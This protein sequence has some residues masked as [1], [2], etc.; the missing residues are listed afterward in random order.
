MANTGRSDM[1]HSQNSEFISVPQPESG[2][3]LQDTE[4]E[5][6][7]ARSEATFCFKLTQFSK[8]EDAVFSP[9]CYIRNLS[10][11]IK[12]MP[13]TR[14]TQNRT[15]QKALGFFLQCNGE[16][17]SS[18]WSCNAVAELRLL[19]V[20]SDAAAFTR[21][22]QH[23]FCSKTIH[24]Y[25]SDFMNNLFLKLKQ[26]MGDHKCPYCM[27]KVTNLFS[28]IKCHLCKNYYHDSCSKRVKTRSDGAFIKCCGDDDI[29]DISDGVSSDVVNGQGDLDF[30]DAS[31]A[32]ENKLEG[33]T[34]T[35]ND[36]KQFYINFEKFMNDKLNKYNAI[37]NKLDNKIDS[38]NKM[39][40]EQSKKIEYNE[41]IVE[42]AVER[43]DSIEADVRELINKECNDEIVLNEIKERMQRERNIIF[44]NIKENASEE[45]DTKTINNL[46]S[47]THIDLSGLQVLRLG[48]H[49]PSIIRP[50]RVRFNSLDDVLWILRNS[51]KIGDGVRCVRRCKQAESQLVEIQLKL[52]EVE[53][54]RA[55]LEEKIQKVQLE[56]K[57]ITL[58]L[59]EAELK[60]SAALK[61][62]TTIESQFNETQAAL[63]E[64]TKQNLSLSSKLRQLEM[65]KEQLHYQLE[66]EQ[67]A[68]RNPKEQLTIPL[69]ETKEKAEDEAEQAA[70]LEALQ[71]QLTEL[72][73]ANDKLKKGKKEIATELEDANI[74][75]QMQTQKVSELEKKQK[76][77][78]KVLAAVNGVSEQMAAERDAAEREAGEEETKALSIG[79][80]LYESSA[81]IKELKWR[82]MQA[83][84]DKPVTDRDNPDKNAHKLENAKRLLESLLG[85]FHAQNNELE[86]AELQL[87]G[88]IQQLK[89]QF[90]RDRQA[91]E[92]QFEKKLRGILNV[93]SDLE[94]ELDE[95]L[96]QRTAAVAAKK[97]LEG[98]LKEVEGQIEL[99]C[100]VKEDALKQLK[101]SQQQ[102]KEAYRDVEEA[103]TARDE[104]SVSC[105]H[106][107]RKVKS[108]EADLMQLSEDLSS[109]E[110][111]RRAVAAERDEKQEELKIN[112][113]KGNLLVDE[114]HHLEARIALLE[115]E[116][117]EVQSNNEMFADKAR[118][119]QL[120][121]E[122]L[123]LEFEL[124]TSQHI[125]TNATI[126]M[127]EAKIANLVENLEIK[128]KER[129]DECRHA[130]QYKEQVEKMNA[131][132]NG[133]K[134]LLGEA[135]EEI[136][137]EKA[138]KIE[139]QYD[140]ADMKREIRNLN[141]KLRG[142]TNTVMLSQC[143]C[144]VKGKC[145][146]DTD[147]RFMYIFDAG[148]QQ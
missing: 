11:K 75:L 97:N 51:K 21:K 69:A 2:M 19:S 145:N 40:I 53:R 80:E 20:K 3:V 82:W 92:E 104:L 14:Y 129:E 102:C 111:A 136:S 70:T 6:D 95:E 90:E 43:I 41:K 17:D 26:E 32:I 105:E 10:W 57:S 37:Y 25:I 33:T 116:L 100:Q 117:E 119:A 76:H 114:K 89:E 125:K 96:N 106:A 13:R 30:H 59:E 61:S 64:E 36:F 27:K 22:L 68:K 103:R 4:M 109:S 55:E 58:Q 99:Q 113:L 65:E 39:L 66:E 108:L 143:A 98:D 148:H 120:T 24:V 72:M 50:L 115:K 12:V 46:L 142:Y 107:E 110:R 130:N 44:F 118:K 1:D 101:K 86:D 137:K 88:Y 124:E 73:V 47:N 15:K 52:V 78:D 147:V 112:I 138:L 60:A 133:L 87:E 139:A 29:L 83:E 132:V 84:L 5:E 123:T 74:D 93:L 94:G 38:S 49:N 8:L 71:K 144:T 54:N 63:E 79:R 126:A 85:E 128:V 34:V 67:E 18:S 146:E 7:E 16:I 31:S 91:Y 81:K 35:H 56:S 28:A 127:L 121:V 23:L 45:E 135:E 9:T 131:E 141:S 42:N 62:R 77:F 140:C 122:Q 134:R 48:K